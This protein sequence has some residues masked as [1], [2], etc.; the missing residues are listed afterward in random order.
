MY[1]RQERERE[2]E[3]SRTKT[4][5]V[6]LCDQADVIV[7]SSSNTLNLSNGA[8]SSSLLKAAGAKIQEECTAKY[9]G[10]ISTGDIAITRGYGLPCKEVFHI[11]LPP[12]KCAGSKHVGTCVKTSAGKIVDFCEY[13]EQN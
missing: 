4:V 13:P 10:G 9:P 12:W 1:K 6:L 2:R 11:T 7:N 8:V 3:N 5:S